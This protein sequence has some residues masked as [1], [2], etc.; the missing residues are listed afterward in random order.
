MPWL[1]GASMPNSSPVTT[2]GFRG[3]P[4]SFKLATRGLMGQRASEPA[5]IDAHQDILRRAS[6]Y[7]AFA[8]YSAC[9][10]V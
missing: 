4:I 1:G 9:S 8:P 7:A 2:R 3:W 6:Q 10:L 5:G